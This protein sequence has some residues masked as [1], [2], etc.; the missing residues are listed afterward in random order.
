[1]PYQ[2]CMANTIWEKHYTVSNCHIVTIW[3]QLAPVGSTREEPRLRDTRTGHTAAGNPGRGAEES[4]TV[5]G[6]K[7]ISIRG[8]TFLNSVNRKR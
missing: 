2:K 8:G 4:M 3:V 6:P 7:T 5:N 1:M